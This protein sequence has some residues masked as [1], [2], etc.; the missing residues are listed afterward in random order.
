MSLNPFTNPFKP[1]ALA[2]W[3]VSGVAAY[4]LIFRPAP[5]KHEVAQPFTDAQR[6][7]WNKGK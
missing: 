4:F 1:T 6:E 5:A 7:A 2:A 3:A